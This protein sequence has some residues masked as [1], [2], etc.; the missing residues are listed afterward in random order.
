M[1]RYDDNPLKE[2]SMQIAD[3]LTSPD[4]KSLTDEYKD[5]LQ[6]Y[7]TSKTTISSP[8]SN[9]SE[10]DAIEITSTITDYK[11]LSSKKHQSVKKRY[12]KFTKCHCG[13][14]MRVN[15]QIHTCQKCG[16]TEESPHEHVQDDV[17]D[18]GVSSA[19]MGSYNTSS[20]SANPIR[21]TGPGNAMYQKKL[22]CKTSDYSKT[23]FKD[24]MQQMIQIT[25]NYTKCTFPPG[26]VKEAGLRYHE[27]QTAGEIKRGN[28]R[29]GA[30]GDCLRRMCDKYGI[31]K[32]RNIFADVFGV[33]L[34][35]I[36]E[37]EKLIDSL[38][39]DGKISRDEFQSTGIDTDYIESYVIQYFLALKIPLPY[40]VADSTIGE[41]KYYNF[42][43]SL[44]RFSIK[45]GL[46]ENSVQ[47]SKCVGAISVLV[48]HC[49]ELRKTIS[50]D[51][52]A[53]E[54]QISKSTFKRYYNIIEDILTTEEPRKQRLHKKLIHLFHKFNIPI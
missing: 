41:S 38:I 21:V 51:I 13:G 39:S 19:G 7:S 52:I 48:S 46:A 24:T 47:Y 31:H 35:D 44:I 8:F 15:D 17:V 36:S 14:I 11:L 20:E 23:R 33:D 30:M 5:I 9:M 42:T 2:F 25:S 28:I 27:I 1:E 16:T 37:G 10:Q 43:K 22:M 3:T 26:V 40:G 32:K 18:D 45:L 53:K 4:I 49:P 50:A 12:S 6:D 54:C 29:K 34:G